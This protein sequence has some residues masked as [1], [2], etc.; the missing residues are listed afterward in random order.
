[1]YRFILKYGYRVESCEKRNNGS[2][3]ILLDSSTSDRPG[4][5]DKVIFLYPRGSFSRE[6]MP[7]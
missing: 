4:W 2:Y 3:R 7:K 1:M 5:G 6:R